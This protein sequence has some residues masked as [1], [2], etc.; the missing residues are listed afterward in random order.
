M[1]VKLKEI[2]TRKKIEFFIEKWN[3]KDNI[4]IVFYDLDTIEGLTEGSFQNAVDVPTTIFLKDGSEITR[5]VKEV[6]ESEKL[7]KLLKEPA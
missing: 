2:I 6:P 4:K 5:V 7:E 3:L 1:G